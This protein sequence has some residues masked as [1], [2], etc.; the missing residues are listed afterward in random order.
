MYHRLLLRGNGSKH[1]D[2]VGFF[3][4]HPLL[5]VQAER[6]LNL[7]TLNTLRYFYRPNS[8]VILYIEIN[9]MGTGKEATC[10]LEVIPSESPWNLTR[11]E[12]EVLSGLA[13]GLTNAEISSLMFCSRSTVATH[14][15]KILVKLKVSNRSAAASIAVS[16]EALLAPLL[17]SETVQASPQLWML[18]DHAGNASPAAPTRP[19]RL[20]LHPQK[21]AIL[22]GSLY[23][24]SVTRRW[25]A[26]GLV[27]ASRLAIAQINARGGVNG[28]PLAHLVVP[29]DSNGQAALTELHSKN[30]DAITLGNL[31]EDTA[32]LIFNANRDYGAP[33]FHTM[34]APSLTDSLRSS[35]AARDQ[36]FSVAASEHAYISGFFRTLNMIES[37]TPWNPGQRKVLLILRKGEKTGAVA[38]QAF[39]L[40]ERGNWEIDIAFVDDQEANAGWSEAIRG[41]AREG[42]EVVLLGTFIEGHLLAFLREIQ[43]SGH[44]PL[45]YSVWA[46]SA[47]GFLKRAGR[48]AE[49]L[50]W[51][52]VIGGYAND[53]FREFSQNYSASFGEDAGSGTAPIHFDLVNLLAASWSQINVPWD[54]AASASILSTIS[55]RGVTGQYRF[56]GP[57]QHE[58]KYVDN[59]LDASSSHF[60]L[61]HQI[62][63]GVDRVISPSA[64][65]NAAFRP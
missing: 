44:S 41:I 21:R 47:P 38:A 6:A 61:V 15:E 51:A 18:L 16:M 58:R 32:R 56:R 10:T 48:L 42:V 52:T 13:V 31:D 40:G 39:D 50:V 9:R 3:D 19:P 34:V 64:V 49:G 60:H 1:C 62:Q 28:R 8:T 2:D 33:L 23:S 5:A 29:I 57:Q 54:F 27:Q 17:D 46:P 24:T 30:V 7:P 63:N 36:V 59:P 20:P 37:S 26:R 45:I 25:E 22:I 55:Y 53:S 43:T 65:A 12:H 14:I 11:R 35:D 4:Q